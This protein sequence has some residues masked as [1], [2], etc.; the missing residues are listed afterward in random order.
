MFGFVH[1]RTRL[2][3]CGHVYHLLSE[4]QSGA[5]VLGSF[6]SKRECQCSDLSSV[7]RMLDMCAI[8]F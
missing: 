2:F 3:M 4:R 1:V 6:N 8:V 7:Y 5:G